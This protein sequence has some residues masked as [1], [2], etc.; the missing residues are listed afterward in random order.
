MNFVGLRGL[1]RRAQK[2]VCAL[3][4]ADAPRMVCDVAALGKPDAATID[5][6]CHA[7]LAAR[8]L[9]WR[10]ELHRCPAELAEL[11]ELCGLSHVLPCRAPP[12]G[13]R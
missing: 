10:I 7:A 11:I 13:G 12:D 2:G 4:T 5:A 9:G 1:E 3:T 6:L 8:R